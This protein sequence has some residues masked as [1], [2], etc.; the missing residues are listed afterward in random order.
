[1]AVAS[2]VSP[3][4]MAVKRNERCTGQEPGKERTVSGG[5]VLTLVSQ[6]DLPVG[7]EVQTVLVD[8][9]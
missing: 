8:L 4:T 5:A 6:A 1:M 3:P 9:P 2:Q 7:N